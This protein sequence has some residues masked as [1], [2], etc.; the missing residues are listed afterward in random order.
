M[1]QNKNSRSAITKEMRAERL[2]LRANPGTNVLGTPHNYLAGVL[3][4][5]FSAL[6]RPA[7]VSTPSE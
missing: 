2:F 4:M 3:T 6:A 5:V 1:T 7:E